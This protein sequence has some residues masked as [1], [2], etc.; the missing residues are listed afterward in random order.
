MTTHRRHF[1]PTEPTLAEIMCAAL[2]DLAPQARTTPSAATDT[3]SAALAARE[4]RHEIVGDDISGDV[5]LRLGPEDAA[6]LALVLDFWDGQV[7][8]PS[9]RHQH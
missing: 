2:D 4:I 7:T 6:L 5:P 1:E 9:H 8:P 3:L